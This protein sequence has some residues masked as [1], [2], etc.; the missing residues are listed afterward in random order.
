MNGHGPPRTA[1]TALGSPQA[2]YAGRRSD[3]RIGRQ[4][5]LPPKPFN[6][7]PSISTRR[8]RHPPEYCEPPGVA[9]GERPNRRDFRNIVSISLP[10]KTIPRFFQIPARHRR[11]TIVMN[12]WNS[13]DSPSTHLTRP[14]AQHW[15]D[16]LFCGLD[17]IR[18]HD[19]LF[20]RQ[21]LYP[22]SYKPVRRSTIPTCAD[23]MRKRYVQTA[24]ADARASW[25]RASWTRASCEGITTHQFAASLAHRRVS[26]RTAAPR[27]AARGHS[28][29]Q[30]C[31][32]TTRALQPLIAR[33]GDS[34]IL[35]QTLA[36]RL[37][38]VAVTGSQIIQ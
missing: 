27:A 1:S 6:R 29:H 9:S 25:T 28:V 3:S 2:S 36:Y 35:E 22:L 20:R 7:Q 8:T 33:L 26:L 4:S 13:G 15:R 17:G 37:N 32:P 12:H 14:V 11:L 23:D 38:L 30:R 18:T 5:P 24:Y 34:E 16:G 19:L 31:Q 21:T 10:R